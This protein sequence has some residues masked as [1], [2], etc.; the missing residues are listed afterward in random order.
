[1]LVKGLLLRVA[2]DT[3]THTGPDSDI[4]DTSAG[5]SLAVR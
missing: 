2:Q 3:T 5:V 1:V 4:R